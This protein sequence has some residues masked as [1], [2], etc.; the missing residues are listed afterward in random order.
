MA[1]DRIETTND[2]RGEAFADTPF[3]IGPAS[4]LQALWR[5]ARMLIDSDAS[6]RCAGVAFFS[7]LALFPLIAAAVILFGL[8][9]DTALIDRIMIQAA[10]FLPEGPQELIRGQ[11][12]ALTSQ[13]SRGLG[14]GLFLTVGFALWSGSRGVNALVYALTRAYK[15]SGE[16]AFLGGT[17]ISI[18]L[19]LG[20]FAVASVAIFAVAIIPVVVSLVPM[21]LKA[22]T[23]GLLLRWPLL[24][25][26]VL[27]ATL[28]LYRLAP[29]R[30]AAKWRW[31]MPGAILATILWMILSLG[32]SFYVENFS[33][34]DSTFGSLAAAVVLMLWMYYSSMVFVFG[35]GF[36]AELELLTMKDT[37]RGP[38][39]P[40]GKRGAVVAD[41]RPPGM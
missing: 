32:F 41:T 34:Y 38:P 30:T 31:L 36:N 20:G 29:Y 13:P 6:L 28:I 37:T 33:S 40:I 11:L 15:E 16:R 19:T 12:E 35:A 8:L 24:A 10:A 26:V 14:I 21:P 2:E 22:E 9:A 1:V 27:V 18:G 7:F 17:L 5:A 39:M 25:L 4:M 3:G 23:L